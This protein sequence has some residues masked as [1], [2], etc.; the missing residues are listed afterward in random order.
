[1]N[2]LTVEQVDNHGSLST[3]WIGGG[4]W[5]YGT[6]IEETD[7]SIKVVLY[8]D[9]TPTTFIKSETFNTKEK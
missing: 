2:K 7:D 5:A 8:D 1:M 9:E 4:I 6:I 3:I